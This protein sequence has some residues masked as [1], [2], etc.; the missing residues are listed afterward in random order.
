[1]P[2]LLELIYF[3]LPCYIAN[4]APVFAR[5]RGQHPIWLKGLGSHKTLEGFI[6]GIFA[7]TFIGLLQG[8]LLAGFL[9]GF[10]AML[11]DSIK[12]FFKRKIG[13]KPGMPWIP[14]DQMD[15][16][17]GGLALAAFIRTFSW[18]EYLLILAVTVT[19]HIFI[20]HLAFWLGIRREKW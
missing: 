1:M 7:G 15:F 13:I 17:I 19:G 9:L 16:A 12:S 18:Q 6:A 2:L 10:G 4:M 8:N 3:M 11:G 20:N 5:R 14:I